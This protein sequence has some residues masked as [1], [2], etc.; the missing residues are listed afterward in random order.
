MLLSDL[1]LNVF[2]LTTNSYEDI[3]VEDSLKAIQWHLVWTETSDTIGCYAT[4]TASKETALIYCRSARKLIDPMLHWEG[5]MPMAYTLVRGN[6]AIPVQCQ[7]CAGAVPVL[8][9]RMSYPKGSNEWD[10]DNSG[11]Q[12]PEICFSR[13]RD[14]TSYTSYYSS[15]ES[16]ALPI[17][18]LWVTQPLSETKPWYL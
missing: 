2:Y 7:S 10:A 14:L 17:R 13:L 5:V 1:R 16:L 8:C 6:T 9:H 3:K 12:W 18:L 11:D 4:K 15:H